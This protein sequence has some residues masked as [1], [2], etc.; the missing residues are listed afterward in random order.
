MLI[1]QNFFST[2]L[3]T[4]LAAT[5]FTPLCGSA[6]TTWSLTR[7]AASFDRSALTHPDYARKIKTGGSLSGGKGDWG[8]TGWVEYDFDVPG[9][10]WYELTVSG[11]GAEVEYLMNSPPPATVT[12][13]TVYGTSGHSLTADKVGNFWL[14]A[15]RHTLRLQ[16]YFWTGFPRIESFTV[17]PSSTALAKTMRA[18][19]SDPAGVY[20]LQGC[21]PLEVFSG[22]RSTPTV[23]NIWFKDATGKLRHTESVPIPR[24]IGLVKH[25]VA[26]ACDEPG[27]FT[28]SFGEN[29]AYHP[30]PDVRWLTYEVIDTRRSSPAGGH[31]N[32]RPAGKTLVEEIDCVRIA[33][34]YFAGGATRIAS[35]AS[36]AE[37]R[38][39]GDNGFTRY[40]RAPSDAIRK[41]LPEPS[42]FA[43]RLQNVI[44]QQPYL[45]EVDY[46]DDKLRTFA[47]ALREGA[48]LSYPVAGGVDSGG[49]FSLSSGVHTESLLYWPRAPGTR[50]TFLNAHDGR[51]AAASKIRVYRLDEPMAPLVPQT[52]A[53]RQFLNW[54]EEGSNFLSMYGALDGDF[55][56][57]AIRWANAAR[58][59]GATI[60]APTVVVYEFALYPSIFNRAFSHPRDD[61]LRRLLLIAEQHDLKILPEVHPR[62]DELAWIVSSSLDP[63]PHLLV[64]R[65]GET[66]GGLPP[67]HNPLYPANQDW[68]VGMIGELAER[69]RDSSALLGVNLRLMQWKNPALNNFHSLDWGYDDFTVGL[70]RKETGSAVPMGEAGESSRF[71]QRHRWLMAN[72]REQWIEW[73]C[74]KIAQLYAR[75]R[76]RVRQ[77]RPDLKVYSS[78][79]RW[80]SAGTPLEALRGAGIDPRILGG[81]SGVELINA[82][83]T[84]GRNEADSLDT[85]RSRDV[86]VDPEYPASLARTD[87]PA[88]FLTS[89]AYLEITDAVAP[90]RA[91]GFPDN[92]KRTWTSGAA[93]PAGRHHLERFAVE[94]AQTDTKLMG[95]G[96]N[97]YSLGQP[98]LREFLSEYLHLPAEP[99]QPRADARDPVAVWERDAPEGGIFYAVN[100]ERY[101][102]SIDLT[103]PAGTTLARLA[104]NAPVRLLNNRLHIDLLPYQLLAYRA[105]RGAAILKV[106]TRIPAAQQATVS[107]QV[108]W[109]EQLARTQEEKWFGKL[110]KAEQQT[111][112][113]VAEESA[114][115]LARGHYWRA[116]MTLE[117]RP[118]L[119]I[120]R[121]LGQRPPLLRFG[122]GTP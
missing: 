56:A 73:R 117:Q 5:A 60:L 67:L 70:F 91:L 20:R 114:A 103:F 104:G 89:A 121:K 47:I 7:Q 80:D 77:A 3:A 120:Y 84:Y 85:Q 90:P 55:T 15:G 88:S 32:S 87:A 25:N 33:P 96:G 13:V 105:S 49:E 113:R 38:E 75:I 99:F 61:K 22:G 35:T 81:I 37:Y 40:Q 29:G 57:A 42:W 66:S 58:H 83:H 68:Y 6:Q 119:A 71:A 122:D 41:L 72:A 23:L 12:P 24:S 11:G 34:D 101:P 115:A 48:P 30:Y 116:R 111:L 59:A 17:T 16:R 46:P 62:A 109:A 100:R 107:A 69:Y 118:M 97:G 2:L 45:V 112:V 31:A 54:Y 8:I 63:K 44:A 108:R 53:G 43:Y 39:S 28:V 1:S 9:S 4:M 86:L 102:V 26:L 52:T 78:F 51:R 14:T 18:A 106:D 36:G 110:D 94:L 64:S 76:D 27:V 82:M 50:V 10:G 65:D 95:D 98:V 74:R 19:L 21:A 93:N 79:F 92:T